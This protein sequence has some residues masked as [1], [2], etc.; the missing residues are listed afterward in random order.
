MAYGTGF[1]KKYKAT[2]MIVIASMLIAEKTLFNNSDPDSS[3]L[4]H[5]LEKTRNN[6]PNS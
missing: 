3:I 5:F 2:T 1:S 6:K 4:K